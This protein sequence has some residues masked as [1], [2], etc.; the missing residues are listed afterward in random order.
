[1]DRIFIAVGVLLILGLAGDWL[2][3]QPVVLTW[4]ARLADWRDR[5]SLERVSQRAEDANAALASMQPGDPKAEQRAL[6]AAVARGTE[7]VLRAAKSLG[8]QMSA[9]DAEAHARDLMA[10]AGLN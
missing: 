8:V 1:M 7:E 3:R 10:E 4:R 6:E 5:R 9:S 2:R